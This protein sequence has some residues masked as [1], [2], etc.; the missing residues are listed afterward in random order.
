MQPGMEYANIGKSIKI[1]CFSADGDEPLL[2]GTGEVSKDCG[3][4]VLVN[5]AQVLRRYLVMIDHRITI[6]KVADAV[7]ISFP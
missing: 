1:I 3:E 2:S 4:D 6:R 7:D 5:W